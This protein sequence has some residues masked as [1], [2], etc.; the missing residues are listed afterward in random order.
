MNEEDNTWDET[1]FEEIFPETVK[2][3]EI[4]GRLVKIPSFANR[5]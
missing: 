5:L 1:D 2:P 4:A 3:V